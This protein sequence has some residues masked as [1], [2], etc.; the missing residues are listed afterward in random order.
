[1]RKSVKMAALFTVLF[2][3]FEAVVLAYANSQNRLTSGN[4]QKVQINST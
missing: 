1:M 4:E 2:L 3:A